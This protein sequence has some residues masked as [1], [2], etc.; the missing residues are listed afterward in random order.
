MASQTAIRIGNSGEPNNGLGGGDEDYAVMMYSWS[1]SW[2]DGPGTMTLPYVLEV[3][4]SI[5]VTTP[6]GNVAF[7]IGTTDTI[8]WSSFGD[9]GTIRIE[10]NRNYPAGSWE[11]LFASTP[12]DGS[13]PWLVSG[14]ATDNARVRISSVANPDIYGVSDANFIICS[15][16]SGFTPMGLFGGH[17]YYV[18]TSNGN[19]AVARDAC[20]AA[21]GYLACIG[22]AEENSFIFQ[23]LN[24]NA[25]DWI[26]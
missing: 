4:P 16:I 18:S 11:T 23:Y 2:N 10:L 22:S 19:M 12:N 9:V 8:R 25:L 17:Y 15:A 20:V 13:E 6:N 26:Y 1:G 21:G 7:S 14:D 24:D 5:H 3:S